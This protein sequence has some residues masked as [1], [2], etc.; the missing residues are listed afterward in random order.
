MLKI[1][2]DYLN[3]DGR[4]TKYFTQ[5]TKVFLGNKAKIGKGSPKEIRKLLG[6]GYPAGID[7]SGLVAN[8]INTIK[9]IRKVLKTPSTNLLKKIQFFLRPIENTNVT[10]LVDQIN[11]ESVKNVQDIQLL[12]IINVG[13]EHVMLVTSVKGNTIHYVNASEYKGCVGMERIVIKNRNYNLAYQEWS[14]K[15]RHGLFKQTK[16]SGVRRLTRLCFADQS[17]AGQVS[18]NQATW[19]L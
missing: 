17:T 8:A 14:D 16:G 2:S 11:S 1:I 13:Q 19:S 10:L 4:P 18:P 6:Q 7:C 12:N 3:I 9:P 15:K 5:N